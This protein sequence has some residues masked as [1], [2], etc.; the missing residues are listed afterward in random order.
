MKYLRSAV[1][2]A[3]LMGL[4]YV[5]H[6]LIIPFLFPDYYRTGTEAAILFWLPLFGVIIIGISLRR[7]R[8]REWIPGDV[9]YGILTNFYST[10][11]AY[12]ILPEVHKI[13]H[14]LILSLFELSLIFAFQGLIMIL[15]KAFQNVFFKDKL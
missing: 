4:L 5:V 10:N 6:F 15:N 3:V 11:G 2:P 8:I 9:L 1:I 7:N 12:N 14:I 13:E